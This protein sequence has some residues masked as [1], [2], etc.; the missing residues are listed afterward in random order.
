VGEGEFRIET[1]SMGEVRVPASAYYGAQTQRAVENFPISGIRFPR[2]FIRAVGLIK[3]AAARVNLNLGLVPP[4]IAS[5][6]IQAATEVVEGSLDRE[7]VL[8]IFQTGSGTSTNMNANEVI[9]N[10]A[11]E[12]LGGARGN[13]S[14][15]HPN[16]HVN[17]CQS[18]N[19][20]IPTAIHLAAAEMIQRGLLPAL[21]AC[22]R[23]MLARSEEFDH[24]VK[25]G[26]TH[27]QDATPVR[28]GQEFGGYAR[29]LIL[30]GERLVQ[31]LAGLMELAFGGTATGSGLNAPPGFAAKVIALLAEETGLP[32]VEAQDHFAAQGGQEALVG[33]SAALRG[34]AVALTKIGNDLRLLSSGPRCGFGEIRL[35]E[36]QPGSSIMPGK[37]NPVIIESL[38]QVAVQV[39][40]NDLAVVLGGQ[41][42]ILELNVMLPVMGHSLLQSIAILRSGITNF[43]ERC[44][45][46]LDANE[47]RCLDLVEG[48][49]ALCTALV[50]EIGYD[51]AAKLARA[52]YESG[53]TVRDVALAMGILPREQI[54]RLLNVAEMTRPGIPGRK[55][56]KRKTEEP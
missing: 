21:R 10:R 37:V 35:P 43:T 13:K 27:L 42:G 46:G 33:A 24:I 18:S 26:R 6:I 36:V 9:A 45:K 5:A 17:R 31:A 8:D 48:S 2:A 56:T 44:L 41:A 34:L 25:I 23:E 32:L 39:M 22:E 50:P 19:D 15:V 51:Q 20:V 29:Q 14:P 47:A 7:F 55:Q 3:R 38:L 1:D 53:K 28:L 4:E 40:A 11:I 49:L 52:A 30:A 16:D 54:E 12:I